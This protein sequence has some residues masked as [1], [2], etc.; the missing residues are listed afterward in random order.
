[1]GGNGTRVGETKPAEQRGLISL[2]RDECR[3][4]SILCF[5]ATRS[6]REQSRPDAER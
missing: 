5:L 2:D 3:L 4:R 1:M 6:D